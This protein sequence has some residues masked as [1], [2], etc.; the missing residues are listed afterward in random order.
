M[1]FEGTKAKDGRGKI[2][3][4]RNAVQRRLRTYLYVTY[5]FRQH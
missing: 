5:T 3:A 1:S 4:Y 2:D